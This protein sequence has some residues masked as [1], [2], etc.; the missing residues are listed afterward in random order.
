MHQQMHLGWLLL[1]PFYS[2]YQLEWTE[3][4]LPRLLVLESLLLLKEAEP[5]LYLVTEYLQSL[6]P[7]QMLQLALQAEL[8][9][10]LWL[11]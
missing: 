4:L 5:L 2:Q 11:E 10:L 1:L 6:E 9:F 7:E 8:V 3:F